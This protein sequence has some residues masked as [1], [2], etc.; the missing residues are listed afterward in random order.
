MFTLIAV[1]KMGRQKKMIFLCVF[2]VQHNVMK[3]IRDNIL[4]V[5]IT[6]GENMIDAVRS[7]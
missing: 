7:F 2:C 5:V 1:N 4:N 6:W 3:P